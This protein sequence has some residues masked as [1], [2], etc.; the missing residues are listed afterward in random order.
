MMNPVLVWH[1]KCCEKLWVKHVTSGLTWSRGIRYRHFE[2]TSPHYCEVM[3]YSFGIGHVLDER[4]LAFTEAELAEAA[5][6]KL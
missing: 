1:K 6:A 4:A 2:I 3:R 5:L